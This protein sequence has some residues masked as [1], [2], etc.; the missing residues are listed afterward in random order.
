M[1]GELNAIQQCRE[2]EREKLMEVV[3]Q[4]TV[5]ASYQYII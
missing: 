4:G 1:S 3:Y 2:K 5:D